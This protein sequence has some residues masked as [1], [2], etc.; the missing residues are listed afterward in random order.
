MFWYFT[1]AHTKVGAFL[2]KK[3]VKN[4]IFYFIKKTF[5]LS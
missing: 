5:I 4:F 1:F 3:H 2:F